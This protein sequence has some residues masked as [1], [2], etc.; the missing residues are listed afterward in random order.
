MGSSAVTHELDRVPAIFGLQMLAAF[1]FPF[2]QG[3][4]FFAGRHG[5]VWSTD[6]IELPG[7]MDG[8]MLQDGCSFFAGKRAECRAECAGGYVL[9]SRTAPLRRMGRHDYDVGGWGLGE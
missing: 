5:F 1:L 3:F 2:F 4:F 8:L 6:G 7:W 9:L